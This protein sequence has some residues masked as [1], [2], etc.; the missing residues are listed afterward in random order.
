MEGA[1]VVYCNSTLQDIRQT[2]EVVHFIMPGSFQNNI[3]EILNE[4]RWHSFQKPSS[5]Q[6]PLIKE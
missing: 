2:F 6:S 1:N 3:S 5:P 4:N